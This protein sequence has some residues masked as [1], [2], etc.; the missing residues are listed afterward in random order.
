MA[1]LILSLNGMIQGEYALNNS[2]CDLYCE[3]R[4]SIG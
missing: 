1:K 4:N 3:T 2:S